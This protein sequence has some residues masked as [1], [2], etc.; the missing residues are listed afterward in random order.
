MTN[1]HASN[2]S[3]E[4]SP[5]YFFVQSIFIGLFSHNQWKYSIQM[6]LFILRIWQIWTVTKHFLFQS[7]IPSS[8]EMHCGDVYFR[9]INFFISTALKIDDIDQLLCKYIYQTCNEVVC[10]PM[11]IKVTVGYF[12]W[13]NMSVDLIDAID[14]IRPSL[15]KC[16]FAVTRL[17]HKIC[18]YSNFFFMVRIKFFF[19]LNQKIMPCALF[20]SFKM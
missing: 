17:T 8:P 16:L 4:C 14:M 2:G 1:C 19:F 11:F 3:A 10:F 7:L 13:C 20:C 6:H 12:N 15:K 5:L 18:P 9:C